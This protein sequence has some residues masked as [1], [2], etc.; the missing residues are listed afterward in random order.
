MSGEPEKK[1]PGDLSFGATGYSVEAMQEQTN[2]FLFLTVGWS[3]GRTVGRSDDLMVGR[4][5]GRMV[6]WSL[7]R[8]VR[9]SD[10]LMVGRSDAR[11]Y[12]KKLTFNSCMTL[13]TRHFWS[14]LNET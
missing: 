12:Q 3:D 8:M 10:G 11:N 1:F 9:R 4:S 14:E 2:T 6:G 5:G 13:A 7:G